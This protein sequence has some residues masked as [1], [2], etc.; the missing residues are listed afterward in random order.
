VADRA[1]LRIYRVA[2]ADLAAG[3]L[4]RKPMEVLVR[5]AG[6]EVTG[7]AGATRTRDALLGRAQQPG[8]EVE[9]ERGLSHGP[10]TDQEQ[11]LRDAPFEHPL[12]GRQRGRLTAR[13]EPRGGTA[14]P[15]RHA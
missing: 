14:R 11:H 12:G 8:R 10:G 1:R 3:S 13:R 5:A 9:S 15:G 2:D 4:R 6:D 7:P